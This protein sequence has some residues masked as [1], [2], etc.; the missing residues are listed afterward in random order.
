[1]DEKPTKRGGPIYWLKRRSRRFW[2]A[3]VVLLPVLYVASFGPAVWLVSGGQLNKRVVECVFWP[4]LVSSEFFPDQ[5]LWYGTLGLPK[6][7]YVTL[8]VVPP[9]GIGY[10]VTFDGH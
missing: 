9:D 2:I 8:E 6:G 3:V 1:M 4:V 7:K 10:S 5:V